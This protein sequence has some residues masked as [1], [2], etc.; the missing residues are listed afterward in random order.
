MSST[1]AA[2]IVRIAWTFTFVVP[3]IL[4]ALLLGAGATHAAPD[5]VAAPLA[6]EEEP[7]AEGEIASDAEDEEEECED[8]ELE[9]EEETIGEA[10]FELLCD[11]EIAEQDRK[12]AAAARAGIAPE[13]CLLRSANARVVAHDSHNDVRLT[14]GYTTYEPTTATV[15]YGF[16]RGKG[17]LRLGT[18]KRHLGR[19]GV[20][21]LTTAL[22]D[23]KMDK[24]EA[25]GRFV[26][27]L[28][29]T[30]SPSSCRRFETEQL[31]VKRA[32][33]AQ[34]IWSEPK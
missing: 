9:F 13:E 31:S 27:R 26:V 11:K 17:P 8:A 5:P 14:V 22:A 28:H 6:F 24:V 7:E 4:T 3:L 10:E 1:R 20:I 2:S 34:A 21:R 33:E 29:V 30:G 12:K 16:G 15:E 23:P 19:S 25:A 18:A 32:S